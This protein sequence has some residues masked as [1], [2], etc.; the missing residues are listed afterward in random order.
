[1]PRVSKAPERRREELM[2]AALG[3]CRDVGYENL[4]I[5]QVT[6]AIGVA[7]GTF[8]YHFG[9]KDALLTALVDRF[10]EGIFAHIQSTLPT[11]GT[12]LEQLQRLMSS[13]ASYKAEQLDASVAVLP[14]LY[15]PDNR[16][17]RD[18]LFDAW[19]DRTRHFLAPILA[20]GAAD[21]SF[22]IDDPETT[23]QLVLTLWIDA[24]TRMWD[25]ALAAPDED[26]FIDI[27]V[28]TA[29]AIWTAQERILGTRPGS[30]SVP[31][32]PAS[33]RGVHAVFLHELR[34]HDKPQ[35]SPS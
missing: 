28:R 9:S 20:R 15:R 16:V 13:A 25:R 26:T 2:D 19:Y 18:G 33:L 31:L 21:G 14:F 32:D 24:G 34:P 12:G 29:Q 23:A 11:Q 3:L 35:G 5:E 6:S 17:L 1:M 22:A 7:K 8:Y 27:L 30:L 10:G 4:L